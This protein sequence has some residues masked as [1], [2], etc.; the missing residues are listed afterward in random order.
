MAPALE[1]P[2]A[3]LRIGLTGGIASGKSTV[4][5]LF[6]MRGVPVID[7]DM[8]AREVVAP[9]SEGLAAVT[10]AF[11]AG[12]LTPE[13]QLD[14][15]ALGR[16]VF[17]DG[18]AR[19]RLEAILH[20]RIRERLTT[21]LARLRAPYALVVVPLLVETGMDRQMDAVIVVDLPE[22]VQRDRLMARDGLSA[23]EADA[24]L[25]SQA[26]RDERCAVANYRIDNS[27]ARDVLVHQVEQLHRR[28]L[29]AARGAPLQRGTA[30][31]E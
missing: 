26:T 15:Q 3:P 25:A 9:G 30:E 17:Q 12:I 2:T 6:A 18:A 22:S 8:L 23:T 31:N 4:A 13:G 24:R 29:A 1:T 21:R 27:G 14:R 7:T 11:G 10:A 28:F 19:R 16:H 5:T 20:P